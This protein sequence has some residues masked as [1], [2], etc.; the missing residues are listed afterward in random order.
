MA[1][2]L[3]PFSNV[4]TSTPDNPFRPKRES[5][6]LRREQA[7]TQY[8][9]AAL[10]PG[11]ELSLNADD[12]T[13]TMSFFERLFQRRP[14]PRTMVETLWTAL[15]AQARDPGWYRDHGVADTLEGRFDMVTAVLALA[16]IRMERSAELAPLTGPL[17]EIFVEEMDGQ[18]RQTGVGD[19]MVGKQIGKLMGTLG[20]RIAAFR[21]ALRDGDEVA[22]ADAARR[23]ITMADDSRIEGLA[24]NLRALSARFDTTSDEAL[25]EGRVA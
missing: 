23:N 20:G 25:L 7:P 10:R 15:V 5:T 16:L 22:V 14:D 3:R 6:A 21:T 11:V 13:R 1:S 4:R 8:D 17:T 18:L 9:G 24:A 2:T 12:M 19:L